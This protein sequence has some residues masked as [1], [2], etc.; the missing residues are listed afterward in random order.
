M[1]MGMWFVPLATVLPAYGYGDIKSLVFATSGVAA[2]ISPL[3]FGALADQRMAPVR[4]LRFL[5]LATAV[6]MALA[7]TAI[8]QHWGKWAVLCFCQLHAL[9]SA[10]TFSI[11][12]TIGER[13]VRASSA[14]FASG[15][16]GEALISASTA[17]EVVSIVNDSPPDIVID[18][19]APANPP[20]LP[21]IAASRRAIAAVSP[22]FGAASFSIS[23][24]LRLVVP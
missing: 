3:I 21:C 5:S 19:L 14:T 24:V 22:A 2:F 17:S 1:A 10:P 18:S 23:P 6:A 13:Q 7:T 16:V 4:V 20:S 9:C 8:S 11:S 15:G 12:S